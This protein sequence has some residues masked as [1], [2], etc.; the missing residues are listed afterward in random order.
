MFYVLCM[1]PLERADQP[2][3]FVEEVSID[4][5][6]EHRLLDLKLKISQPSPQTHQNEEEYEELEWEK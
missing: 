5:L 3:R 4:S 6:K 1:V 2:L